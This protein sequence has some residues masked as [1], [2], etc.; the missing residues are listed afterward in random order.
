[1]LRQTIVGF[2]EVFRTPSVGSLFF[3]HLTGYSTFALLVGLWGGPYF[4][5]VYG[6]GLQE[7][8]QLLLL[9]AVAQIVGSLVW[10][11]TDRLMRSYKGPVLVGALSTMAALL[12]V[13]VA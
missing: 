6:L 9:P 8:G 10:G 5:H 11:P 7:R 4:T 2:A 3:V 12:L 13:A 1:T